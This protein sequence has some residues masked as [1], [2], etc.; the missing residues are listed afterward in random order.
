MGK[1]IGLRTLK[2]AIA[3]F[4]CLLFYILLKCFELIPGVPEDF[5][6]SWY[7]P[8]FAG[9]ATAYS[10]HAS[11]EASLQQA[12]NRCV[13]S[14]IGGV[15]GILLITL[16]ELCGGTWPT[17][18][19]ISFRDWSFLIAYFLIPMTSIVVVKIAIAI[20]QQSAVFVAILTLLSVTVNPNVRV[21]HWQWLFGLNRILSTIIGVL[22]ALGV[23]WMRLPRRHH[24]RQ[25]LFCMGV[26]GMLSNEKDRF[27]GFSRYKLNHL[28]S[29]GMNV[30]LFTTRTPATF[31]DLLTD[32]SVSHPIVCMSGAALY[33]AKEKTYLESLPFS[34]DLS[35][36]LRAEFSKMK[37]TPFVNIIQNDVLYIYLNHVD[38]EGE[39]RYMESKKNAAYCS[40]VFEDAP[41]AEV[42]YFLLVEPKSETPDILKHLAL[43]E[44]EIFIQVFD[45]FDFGE[46]LEE[47]QYIKVY[48]KE[49]EQLNILHQYCR[50]HQL[51][52]VGMTTDKNSNHLLNESKIAVTV[53]SAEEEV[54]KRC[55]KVLKSTSYD[56]LFKEVQR[57]YYQKLDKSSKTTKNMI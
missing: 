46:N 26:D 2:T 5:A 45:C 15:V 36:R 35:R 23:N 20:H 44:N 10:M 30:T 22:I 24:N 33:D 56:E 13:A 38:N 17:L 39:R 31:M 14:V 37:I 50:K 29:L 9:I 52:I 54:K 40:F 51:E 57:I 55:Q 53:A 19:T 16:Y 34:L 41:E 43:F 12:K 42:L 21:D 1:I 11:K 4:F 32:V 8:F 18:Q 47:L 28:T 7:N 48:R 6:Y 3:I 49:V 25:L 27:K